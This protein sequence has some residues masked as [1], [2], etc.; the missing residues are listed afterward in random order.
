MEYPKYVQK[1]LEVLFNLEFSK[2][3][4]GRS[5]NKDDKLAYKLYQIAQK[6]PQKWLIAIIEYLGYMDDGSVELAEEDY[7]D[8]ILYNAECYFKSAMENYS[9]MYT[10][11]EEEENS[12]YH[13]WNRQIKFI[14]IGW[15]DCIYTTRN[16]YLNKY[17]GVTRHPIKCIFKD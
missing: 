8:E 6:Y 3:Q 10:D 11:R 15:L 1:D 7:R 9:L 4:Y 14:D 12:D 17:Q 2:D 5:I 13:R 16:A